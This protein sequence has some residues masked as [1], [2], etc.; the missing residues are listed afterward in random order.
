MLACH[1]TANAADSARSSAHAPIRTFCG[2]FSGN[3]CKI[4]LVMPKHRYAVRQPTGGTYQQPIRGLGDLLTYH[5]CRCIACLALPYGCFSNRHI[6]RT[7]YIRQG[8]PYRGL[9]CAK[10]ARCDGDMQLLLGERGG[11]L[12]LASGNVS[13]SARAKP[14][15]RY[16]HTYALGRWQ[17]NAAG[18]ARGRPAAGTTDWAKELE[19]HAA[20]TLRK[21]L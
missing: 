12:R 13:F 4:Y 11:M 19:W 21:F 1:L 3:C 8:Q 9:T 15:G 5:A 2:R 6:R 20:V 18:P 16:V 17:M 14:A 10:Y 7:D